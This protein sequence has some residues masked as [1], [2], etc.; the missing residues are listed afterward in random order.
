MV[1]IGVKWGVVNLF[2]KIYLSGF[3]VIVMKYIVNLKY[4]FDICFGYYMF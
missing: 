1:F 4:F 3:L 2:D